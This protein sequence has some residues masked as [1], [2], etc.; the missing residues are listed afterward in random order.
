M[1]SAK[2]RTPSS[3][4]ERLR[5]AW[6]ASA[7]CAL[8]ISALCALIFSAG[9]SSQAFV[10]VWNER[11][12]EAARVHDEGDLDAA[13]VHYEQL[14]KHAPH[15]EAR[16]LTQYHLARLSLDRG[17]TQDAVARFEA[18]IQEPID[19]EHGARAAYQLARMAPD[20]DARAARCQPILARYHEHV[21]AEHC[22]H[23]MRRRW[24]D[25]GQPQRFIQA[26]DA[27]LDGQLPPKSDLYDYALFL[28][29]RAL[30]QDLDDATAALAAYDALYAYDPKG[31]LADD[32]LWES[33]QIFKRQARWPQAIERLSRLVK[34]VETSW[35]VGTYE[36]EFADD[37]RYTMGLIH[38]QELGLL[39]EAIG[40]FEAFI[41]EFP[42]SLLRDDAAWQIVECLH[43][44][45][46][47]SWADAARRFA[48][49]YPE[50]R[51][52]RR[53]QALLGGPERPR[54]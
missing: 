11:Y 25:Q 44:Q 19:D 30:D 46:D 8:K 27:L 9:C 1:A 47:P 23:D 29:A 6:A 5:P 43:Q 45:Q 33:A 13:Q 38:K 35:F 36:S 32:A 39:P 2:P 26:L 49:D 4:T 7:L 22:L 16:R 20:E 37:A 15:A 42:T 41:Q 21:A 28:K 50:S 31:A 18:I 17:Q 40:H 12:V 53:A 54:P 52:V 24:R 51:H 3:W 34:D 14:L 48:Q 10:H